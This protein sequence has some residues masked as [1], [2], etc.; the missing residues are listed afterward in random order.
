MWGFC[1][2]WCIH[3]DDRG[4]R[5]LIIVDY[6][7][8][9]NEVPV[10]NNPQLAGY[11]CCIRQFL[12]DNGKDIDYCRAAIYQ[13]N[14]SSGVSYKET[15]FTAKQLDRWKQKFYK[16]AQIIFSGKKPKFKVG[17]W[18]KFCPAVA[19]CETRLKHLEQ[20][21][22][23]KLFEPEE[24]KFPEPQTLP[25]EVLVKLHEY[26]ADFKQFFDNVEVY[27]RNLVING[28]GPEGYKIVE[29]T[30]RRK[31]IDD[32]TELSNYLVSQNLQDLVQIKPKSITAVE[33]ALKKILDAETAAETMNNF[34]T[35]GQPK[36]T[37]V[38]GKDPRP[39]IRNAQD[40]M[41]KEDD[42]LEIE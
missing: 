11:A 31:W 39:A 9:R 6:K 27:L 18:C 13:P 19:V 37:L 4:K 24:I 7:N 29:S 28:Q 38:S 16:A 21:T 3:T 33:K 1:D 12:Q 41:F 34:T 14:G 40:L 35:K 8:G 2:F 15:S 36:L 26:K 10:E 22:Q 25:L 30:P 32:T 42:T 17:S 23:L 5:V 20:E